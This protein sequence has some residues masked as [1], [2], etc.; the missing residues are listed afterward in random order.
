[1]P[2]PSRNSSSACDFPPNTQVA[3]VSPTR[4]AP[5]FWHRPKKKSKSFLSAQP[6]KQSTNTTCQVDSGHIPAHNMKLSLGVHAS[7]LAATLAASAALWPVVGVSAS[8]AER[9]LQNNNKNNDKNNNNDKNQQVESD[10]NE[11]VVQA[12][13]GRSWTTT[14]ECNC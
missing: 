4:T 13:G 14:R 10:K 11:E 7:L 3:Q 1:M 8:R 12:T 9:S 5:K 6:S 2:V